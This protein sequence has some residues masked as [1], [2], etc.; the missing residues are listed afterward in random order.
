MDKVLDD[1][2][3]AAQRAEQAGFDMLELH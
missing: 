1:Y 2:V 3:S